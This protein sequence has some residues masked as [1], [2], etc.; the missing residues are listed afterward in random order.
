MQLVA[1]GKP[2][3][4]V[5]VEYQRVKMTLYK[6]EDALA[7]RREVASKLTHRMLTALQ[8]KRNVN[9]EPDWAPM[10]MLFDA[11]LSYD[12]FSGM[13]VFDPSACAPALLKALWRGFCGV[14]DTI[15]NK[16]MGQTDAALDELQMRLHEHAAQITEQKQR[17]R[18]GAVAKRPRAPSP[19]ASSSGEGTDTGAPARRQRTIRPTS[20]DDASAT[21]VLKFSGSDD[22]FPSVPT[23]PPFP[24]VPTHPPFPSVPTHPPLPGGISFSAWCG[25]LVCKPCASPAASPL[26][27][28]T[29][30]PNAPLPPPS[31]PPSPPAQS[32]QLA[33]LRG[34]S[35]TSAL[36]RFMAG[37]DVRVD[38]AGKRGKRSGAVSSSHAA[39]VAKHAL[40]ED[41]EAGDAPDSPSAARRGIDGAV[42]GRRLL[43]AC[44]ATEPWCPAARSDTD[45]AAEELEWAARGALPM[46]RACDAADPPAAVLTFAGD[47]PPLWAVAPC[48]VSLKC[49]ASRARVCCGP[50]RATCCGCTSG[51]HSE[52]EDSLAESDDEERDDAASAAGFEAWQSEADARVLQLIIDGV[53]RMQAD[54]SL[55]GHRR[56][57]G[58]LQHVAHGVPDVFG[59]KSAYECWRHLLYADGLDESSGSDGSESDDDLPLPPPRPP[60]VSQ[61]P[62]APLPL[63]EETCCQKHGCKGCTPSWPKA[64]KRAV[65]PIRAR[66][67]ADEAVAVL[68]FAGDAPT[69]TMSIDGDA[70]ETISIEGDA[71]T[72]VDGAAMDKALSAMCRD[73]TV[74]AHGKLCL[75]G[76]YALHRQLCEQGDFERAQWK[77][78]DI[79]IFYSSGSWCHADRQ[80]MRCR[81]GLDGDELRRRLSVMARSCQL[82]ML[83]VAAGVV[84][85]S[86]SR[87]DAFSKRPYAPCLDDR[88]EARVA[89]FAREELLSLCST[90]PSRSRQCARRRCA[91]TRGRHW[92]DSRSPLV[93]AASRQVSHS[94]QHQ[95]RAPRHARR[96]ATH[97][98][99][100][101]GGAD[102]Q[103]ARYHHAE[104][105]L[106]R[107]LH[108]RGLRRRHH[109]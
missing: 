103:C 40:L 34:R 56:A 104:R 20:D 33:T 45:W 41:E 17:R 88:D 31:P 55:D 86:Q 77:P 8:R 72:S 100:R 38:A 73:M 107:A 81:P 26:L 28:S 109:S 36:D 95:A 29:C 53:E 75:A 5:P 82:Q 2:A 44:K 46:L 99:P 80:L 62:P 7:A 91:R 30:K 101:G 32:Q 24:S 37:E 49:T 39:K 108:L 13:P 12:P 47:D 59:S 22:T 42:A 23:H 79:D 58:V 92:G 97:L 6:G 48:C 102:H 69:E 18:A 65:R 89:A 9:D 50:P 15:N 76:S 52:S 21:S 60:P 83:G 90:E 87:Y 16:Q 51:S 98:Q 66:H 43:H 105:T 78:T 68:K 67:E 4:V 27:E 84:D 54:A 63:S 74:L 35:T 10:Q 57:L 61:L 94:L 96:L 85:E 19:A 93:L 14:A 70:M 3:A 11:D 64:A 71:A 25:P 106:A 1:S